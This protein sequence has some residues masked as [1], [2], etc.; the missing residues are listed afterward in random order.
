MKRILLIIFLTLSTASWSQWSQRFV[1]NYAI[2]PESDSPYNQLHTVRVTE[3]NISLQIDGVDIYRYE[4]VSGSEADTILLK[5]V[6]FN[7]Q[8]PNGELAKMRFELNLSES[9][10]LLSARIGQRGMSHNIKLQR[11]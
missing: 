4:W 9:E 8:T 1:S 6:L 3:T 11:L 5:C 10:E 7:A 2:L